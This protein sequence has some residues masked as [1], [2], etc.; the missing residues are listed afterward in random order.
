MGVGPS[1]VTDGDDEGGSIAVRFDGIHESVSIPATQLAHGQPATTFAGG[2]KL[3]AVVWFSGQSRKCLSGVELPK[4][5]KGTVVGP[6]PKGD[7]SVAV[8]F[9]DLADA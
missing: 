3:G 8:R 4:G 6:D 7:T 1:D 5:T 9:P 2:W